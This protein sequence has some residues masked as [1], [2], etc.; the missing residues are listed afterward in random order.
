MFLKERIQKS[1]EER[2]KREERLLHT[3]AL[4]Q[5][6]NLLGRRYAQNKLLRSSYL[7]ADGYLEQ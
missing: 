7:I 3:Q 1:Q 2:E 6:G 5:T 4:Q